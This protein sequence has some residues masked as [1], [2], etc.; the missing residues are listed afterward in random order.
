MSTRLVIQHQSGSKANQVE[1]FPLETTNELTLGRDPTCAIVFDAQRDDAV[2]RRHAIIRVTGGDRP[3]FV[4]AD[5]GSSNGTLVNGTR[6][7]AET[8]LLP[9]DTVQLGRSGPTFVFEV[10]PRPPHLVARTRVISTSVPPPTTRIAEPTVAATVA[11]GTIVPP[12]PTSRPGVGR[13]TVQRML[14]A[15]RQTTS[16][17]WMYALAAVIVLVGAGGGAL[18]Y[19]M[20]LDRQR[21][22]EQIAETA[23]LAAERERQAEAAS[24][25]ALERQRVELVAES[26]RRA[27][28]VK[29]EIGMNPSEV[30]QQF[31]NATVYLRM[32]WRLVDR[33]TG[34]AL[35]H[36]TWLLNGQL[37]PAYIELPD[38]KIV[39]WLTTE[40]EERTNLEVGAAGSGSGFVINDQGYILT[41]KHVAAGWLINYNQFSP[42]EQGKGVLFQLQ[43]DPRKKPQGRAF[44]VSNRG[45]EFRDLINW[46]PDKGGMIFDPTL[47]IRIGD[48]TRIFEGRNDELEVRFPGSRISIAARL[49]RASS[50]ADV[51]L[52]KIDS[53][54]ALTTVQMAPDDAV[55]VGGA[56]TVLGYPGNSVKT[57]ASTTTIERGELHQQLEIVPEPTVT[58][59]VIARLSVAEEQQGAVTVIGPMGDLYQLT[60]SAGAGN[61]GGPVFDSAGKVIGLF[62]YGTLRET[63]TLAVPIRYGRDL[64]PVQRKN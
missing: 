55:T 20:M 4:I 28:E 64:M 58:P 51:A 40:D 50:D 44:D 22:A 57:Y 47:P 41:N 31:G 36:K 21:A 16:R 7:T 29:R 59:G 61:S 23:R 8:E 9:G 17:K 39:R 6:I 5:L 53:P 42:Y 34:K 24:A 38:H 33:E 10:Q 30:V 18:Y 13:E 45:D 48:S 49:V 37:L 25:A 2:S 1:Q 63:M 60:A 26:A 14:T 11:T 56:V 54:E 19:R 15:E 32:Q 52:I 43:T 62:T 3:G 46:I 27:S 35:F 12:P